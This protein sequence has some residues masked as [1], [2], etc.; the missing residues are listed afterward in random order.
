[1]PQGRQHQ[2]CLRLPPHLPPHCP[3][4]GDDH[5]ASFRECRA[6]PIPPPQPEVPPPSD[7]ERSDAPS[8]SE[9]AMDMGDDGRPVP[10]TPKAPSTQTIHLSTPRPLQQSRDA[11]TTVNSLQPLG[12]IPSL[13]KNPRTTSHQGLALATNLTLVQHNSLGSWDV[14]LS[15]FSSLAQGPLADIVLLQDP[16]SSKGF[17]SS[18]A[19]FKSFASPV[20][21]PRVACYVSQKFLHKFAVPPFCPPER[22]DFMALDVFT[23]QGCFGTSFPRFTIGNAYARPLL[24]SLPS[25][26]PESSLFELEHPYLVAGAFNIHY[27]ATNPSRLLSSKEQRESVPYFE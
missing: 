13:I 24:P 10:F 3:N 20:A 12:F 15:L 1:M 27:A 16:S 4:C 22:D 9:E 8:D 14:F 6:R 25:V 7:E 23:L 11:P 18:F 19:G 21:R 17:L 2:G 5:D 26:S